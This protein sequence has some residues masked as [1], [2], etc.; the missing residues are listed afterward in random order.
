MLGLE[1]LEKSVNEL[2]LL[3]S[4]YLFDTSKLLTFLKHN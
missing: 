3:A 4:A 1:L 2:E